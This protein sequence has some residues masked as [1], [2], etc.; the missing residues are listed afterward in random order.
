MERFVPFFQFQQF[1]EKNFLLRFEIL[2][3]N[4][5]KVSIPEVLLR[6]NLSKSYWIK[7]KKNPGRSPG[8][9]IVNNLLVRSNSQRQFFFF[10]GDQT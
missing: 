1:S 6:Q 7:C 10:S 3:L 4:F 8:K 5:F 2:F 9:K